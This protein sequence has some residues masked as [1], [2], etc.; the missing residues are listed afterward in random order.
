MSTR[1]RRL[2][3]SAA[4]CSRLP[5]RLESRAWTAA[6]GRALHPRRAR[7]SDPPSSPPRCAGCSWERRGREAAAPAVLEVDGRYAQHLCLTRGA[8]A[9]RVPGGPGPPA[10]RAPT[11]WRIALDRARTP[12]RRPATSRSPSVHAASRSPQDAPEHRA[13]A[14]APVLHARPDDAG[15]LQRRAPGD[16]VRDRSRRRRRDALR[17][18]VV[19]SNEDGGTPPD[20]LMATWGRLTDIEYVLRHRARPRGPRARRRATRAKDHQLLPFAGRRDGPR[21]RCSTWSPTTTCWATARRSRARASRR[22][23]LAFDLAGVSREAVMDAHPWTYRVS[24]AGGA[25]RGARAARDARPGDRSAS[26][27]RAASPTL[28]ACARDEGRDARLR[29]GR[30][31]RRTAL[32]WF[33]SDGGQPEFR[34]VALSRA[35]SRTAASAARSRCPRARGRR[36]PA[37]RCAS[38]RTRARRARASRRCRRAP[39]ARGSRRVNTAVP[40]STPPD[41]PAGTE[42]AR[43]GRCGRSRDPLAPGGPGRWSRLPIGGKEAS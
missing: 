43:R 5:A 28:E 35:T 4:S 7:R 12:R 17:Y 16:V 39:V 14:H 1:R 31:P 10:P 11:G 24:V 29:R 41:E 20:R 15:P 27:T 26:P 21:I 19:F 2:L 6:V 25:P 8:R 13:L 18:S 38:A 40:A 22:R 23:R 33:E 32:R 9:G 30:A 3:G 34:I 36:A 42:P 37:R